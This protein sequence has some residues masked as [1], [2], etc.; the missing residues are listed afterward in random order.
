MTSE[1]LQ[2]YYRE[3]GKDDVNENDEFNYW[4]NNEKTTAIKYFKCKGK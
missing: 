2:G 1:C 4:M 3:K